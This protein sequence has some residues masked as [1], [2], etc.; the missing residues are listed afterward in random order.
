MPPVVDKNNL[1]HPPIEQIIRFETFCTLTQYSRQMI[2][3]HMF[4][5]AI[6]NIRTHLDSIKDSYIFYLKYRPFYR[7]ILDL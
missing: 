5:E 6:Q 7:L 4:Q 2:D 3:S 1:N